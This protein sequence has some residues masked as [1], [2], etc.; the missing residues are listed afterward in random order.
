MDADRYSISELVGDL[1]QAWAQ[2]KDER[3]ILSSIRPLV[4]RAALSNAT[5]LE[6][7]MYHAS[8]A[9]GFGV[10]LVHEEPDHTLA[11][12]AVS[13]LPHRG[14][15]YCEDG[16]IIEVPCRSDQRSTPP[17]HAFNRTRRCPAT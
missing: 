8:E 16:G 3:E 7:R 15:V 17:T 10:Y 2:F 14:A 9:Q 6:D 5:W 13:W 1:K 4:R 11:V 12:L